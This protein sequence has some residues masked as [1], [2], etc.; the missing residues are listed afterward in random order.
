MKTIDITELDPSNF[1]WLR[2]GKKSKETELQKGRVYL[3]PGQEAPEG[4]QV[5]SGP[6]GGQFY[7]ESPIQST[8][9][10]PPITIE[11]GGPISPE[12]KAL[13]DNLKEIGEINP[14]NPDEMIIDD[15]K[16]GPIKVWDDKVNLT[17]L[18][19][20]KPRSG[21]GSKALKRITDLADKHG[22]TLEDAAV[23]FKGADGE[24]IPQDKLRTFYIRHGYQFLDPNDPDKMVR[25]PMKPI[26]INVGGPMVE[27][28]RGHE[29]EE[30]ASW[31]DSGPSFS[32]R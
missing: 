23:P 2:E 10:A 16:V 6:R 14:E 3:E 21:A 8:A 32:I 28:P 11:M 4:V 20:L 24:M 29:D 19:S 26:T 25:F 22:V 17:S 30:D 15:V 9:E 31:D 5:Q 12:N 27:V 1:N 18:T 13:I 7:D